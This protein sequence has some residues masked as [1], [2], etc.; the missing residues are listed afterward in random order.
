MRYAKLSRQFLHNPSSHPVMT[1]EGEEMPFARKIFI[2]LFLGSIIA[3]DVGLIMGLIVVM[4]ASVITFFGSFFVILEKKFRS[5]EPQPEL[6]RWEKADMWAGWLLIA[7]FP[8]WIIA[9]ALNRIIP[10]VALAGV[11]MVCVLYLAKSFVLIY[12]PQTVREMN[13][14]DGS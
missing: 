13:K 10:G 7:S 6:K 3:F 8:S 12:L 14:S 9:M 11:M 2:A 1:N 5:E 4:I